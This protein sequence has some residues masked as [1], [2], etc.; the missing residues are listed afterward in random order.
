MFILEGNQTTLKYTYSCLTVE[1]ASRSGHANIELD[2]NHL[3][4]IGG[5]K[6]KVF[7]IHS[8][9]INYSDKDEKS[10]IGTIIE[11]NIDSNNCK[12]LK[13]DPGGRRGAACIKISKSLCLIH[14]G[15]TFESHFRNPVDDILVFNVTT[16]KWYSVGETGI[17]LQNH[18]ICNIEG[19]FVIHGGLS[20]N[21]QTNNLTYEIL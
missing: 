19:R 15:E 9:N 7:E 4:V 1:T 17:Q 16:F 5:R 8:F 6:D 3:M 11:A 2:K 18:T 21:N 20:V 10:T 13:K 14:G 12:A